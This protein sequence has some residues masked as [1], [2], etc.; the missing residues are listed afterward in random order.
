MAS[1]LV[2]VIVPIYKVEE[3]LDSCVNSLV[4]QTYQNLEIILVDDGS[5]DRCP[6]ICDEWA[7]RDS[8]IR[9]IHK[10]NGG[11]SDARNA[12]LEIARGEYLCFVDSD[13]FVSEDMCEV[14]IDT[15]KTN[16]A[17]IVS[18]SFSIY[19]NGKHLFSN[20]FRSRCL[21]SKE[22]MRETLLNGCI[23]PSVCGKLFSRECFANV[24]FPINE[25]YEDIAVIPKLFSKC[26]CVY[27]YEKPLYA[28][29]H[30]D[31][32]ITKS[33]YSRKH[34]DRLLRDKQVACDCIVR[35]RWRQWKAF[36]KR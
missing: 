23:T 4:H 10:V 1:E 33:A 18:T 9:V 27:Y 2:T 26:K 3:Y 32:S 17:D 28:Y 13:D 29:R 35:K 11:L 36:W 22:A 7:Q 31:R 14:M 34:S 20:H 25:I 30:N 8:R 24:R 16:Q 19:K 6:K 15:L 5:P 21:T 12:A